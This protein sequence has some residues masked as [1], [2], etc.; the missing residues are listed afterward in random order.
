MSES[1]LGGVDDVLGDADGDVMAAGVVV[2]GGGGDGFAAFGG[3][4][5]ESLT[6]EGPF[7]AVEALEICAVD[8]LLRDDDPALEGGE[9]VDL[10]CLEDLDLEWARFLKKTRSGR[11]GVWLDQVQR[12]SLSEW[13]RAVVDLDVDGL[14]VP[15][16]PGE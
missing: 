9:K 4:E 16:A 6:P 3:S 1:P 10:V 15:E 8:D 13:V 14:D 2:E 5:V 12:A 7:G 11:A